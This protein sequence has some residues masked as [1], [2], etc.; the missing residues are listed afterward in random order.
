MNFLI[1]QMLVN[2]TITRNVQMRYY[3]RWDT[4]RM[5]VGKK[6]KLGEEKTRQVWKAG[7]A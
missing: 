2:H 4:S 5:A 3:T 1:G 7:M 6:L